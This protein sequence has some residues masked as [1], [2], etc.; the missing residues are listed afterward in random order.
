MLRTG[1]RIELVE[2]PPGTFRKPTATRLNGTALQRQKGDNLCWNPDLIRKK[3][4]S[5]DARSELG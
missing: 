2:Y 4:T 5:L 3:G 1:K